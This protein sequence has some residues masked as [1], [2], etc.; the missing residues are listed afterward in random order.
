VKLLRRPRERGARR[1]FFGLGRLA[2]AV[3]VLG[4]LPLALPLAV[5]FI[6]LASPEARCRV[7]RDHLP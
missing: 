4:L 2:R 7:L 3:V 6:A 1:L 5:P